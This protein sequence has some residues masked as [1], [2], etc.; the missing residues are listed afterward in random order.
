MNIFYQIVKR[1]NIIIM[2]VVIVSIGA[3]LRF[4]YSNMYKTITQAER[5]VL[6]RGQIIDATFNEKLWKGITENLETK[7]SAEEIPA[8][9]KDPFNF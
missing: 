4:L 9:I 8:N 6:L 2:I 7:K 3:T 1:L 5:I